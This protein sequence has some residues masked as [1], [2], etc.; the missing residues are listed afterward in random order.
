MVEEEDVVEEEEEED[1][2]LAWRLVS[3]DA[4]LPWHSPQVH[5]P[6]CRS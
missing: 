4:S 6:L 3:W 2:A 1:S 5:V